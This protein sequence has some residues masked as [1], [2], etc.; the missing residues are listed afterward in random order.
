MGLT[1]FFC[2][3][4]KRFVRV[5]PAGSSSLLGPLMKPFSTSFMVASKRLRSVSLSPELCTD[6]KRTPR[7]RFETFLRSSQVMLAGRNFWLKT[8]DLGSAPVKS[9]PLLMSSTKP[10]SSWTASLRSLSRRQSLLSLITS[11]ILGL[12]EDF[13]SRSLVESSLD[14]ATH[15]LTSS[16]R[17]WA[18]WYT[19]LL[20]RYA[21]LA[22]TSFRNK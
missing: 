21:T 13:R 16:V 19:V 14:R 12:I 3:T 22:L 6:S 10:M 18:T 15:L 4:G 1:L 9:K 7:L 8:P 2:F 11:A 17:Y 20:D 5:D